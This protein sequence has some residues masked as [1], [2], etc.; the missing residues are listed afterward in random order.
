MPIRVTIT[1]IF[2]SPETDADKAIA[3]AI[4][5]SLTSSQTVIQSQPITQVN[6][7]S[8]PPHVKTVAPAP[9]QPQQPA[10]TPAAAAPATPA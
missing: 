4:S 8:A 3:D 7:P 9:G 2:T 1:K 6:P 5:G 10:I